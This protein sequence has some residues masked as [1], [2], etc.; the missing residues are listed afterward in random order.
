MYFD[1]CDVNYVESFIRIQSMIIPSSA[2]RVICV[3]TMT[4]KWHASRRVSLQWHNVVSQN[5]HYVHLLHLGGGWYS[6]RQ[7]RFEPIREG[8]E[9]SYGVWDVS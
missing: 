4:R 6:N 1:I 9:L 8:R 2:R 7:I 3:W 5:T